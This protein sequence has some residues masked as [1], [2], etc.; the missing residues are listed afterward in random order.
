MS[1]IWS[2]GIVHMFILWLVVVGKVTMIKSIMILLSSTGCNEFQIYIEI[3]EAN[4]VFKVQANISLRYRFIK[5]D[6]IMLSEK[7]KSSY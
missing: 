1:C 6:Y 5:S 2:T 3:V 7:A 4:L